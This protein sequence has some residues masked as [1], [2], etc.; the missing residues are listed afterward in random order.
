MKKVFIAVA[1]SCLASGLYAQGVTGGLKAGANI[2]NF[3]GGNF[4]VVKKKAIVG[5]HAGG[6]LNFS[7][8][9]ISLQPE[10]LVSTQGARIDSVSGSYD[11]KLV[12]AAVPVMLKYR[13]AGGF[14]LE[15]GPQ[16]SFKISEDIENETIADFAKG[17]DLSAGAGLGFQTK[18]GFGIGARY[19]V[20]LSKVGDFELSEGGGIDPDFKNS[21]IQ[22]GISFALGK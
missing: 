22:V 1:I 21:V 10:L 15:A 2:T 17:L 18:G 3:T 19:L 12:Y 7:L 4:D 13:S 9:A 20:G 8:G 11:W 16:F 5:F 14:Y 6:W